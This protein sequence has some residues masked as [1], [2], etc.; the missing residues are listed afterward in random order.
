MVIYQFSNFAQIFFIVLF[1][2]I[3]LAGLIIGIACI[4]LLKSLFR[5]GKSVKAK[6]LLL[7]FV[8]VPIYALCITL[9]VAGIMNLP[10]YIS[11]VKNTDLEK[12]S[13]V[14]GEIEEII[15][16]PQYGRGADLVSYHIIFTIDGNMYYIDTDVGVLPENIEYWSI[17]ESVKVYY[18]N[19]D[20]KNTVIR[21]EK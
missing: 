9:I 6:I 11:M 3:L 4:P 14:E 2:I 8:C 1:S 20:N 7:S 13:I 12:C 17:G 5:P 15:S 16:E 21:V 18:Q 10:G 19:S